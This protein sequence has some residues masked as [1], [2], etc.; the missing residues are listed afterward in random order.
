[1]TS[2]S[3]KLKQFSFIFFLTIF[4]RVYI[5]SFQDQVAIVWFIIYRWK[6][7]EKNTLNFLFWTGLTKVLYS[8]CYL[9]PDR[10]VIIKDKNGKKKND[11]LLYWM[12]SVYPSTVLLCN[13]RCRC[14]LLKTLQ[15]NTSKEKRKKTRE[16]VHHKLI[17]LLHNSTRSVR[18][19]KTLDK[20]PFSHP[21]WR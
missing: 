13:T 18:N 20:S 6:D 10:F 5:E 14:C 1:M 2:I 11:S 21:Y 3:L 12:V 16:R 7:E 8:C 17:E 19:W 4:T 9:L 15:S